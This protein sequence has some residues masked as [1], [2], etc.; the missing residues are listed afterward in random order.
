[1]FETRIRV[2]RKRIAPIPVAVVLLGATLF[3][4]RELI[5]AA[6]GDF[7]VVQDK[8][9]A[10]DI[11]HVIA[12]HDDRTDHAILLYKQGYGRQI[13]FTG[14]WCPDIREYHGKHGRERALQLGIPLE[15]IATDDSSVTSTYSEVVRLKEFIAKSQ[16]PIHSVIVVSDPFHMRRARWTYRLLLD[17][18]VRIQMA[19][20]PFDSTPYQ[21]RWWTDES[22]RSYVENEY[23][24]T[25]YYYARYKFAAGPI[26]GWLARFDR[27]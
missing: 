7:L 15:A 24:K 27:D 9:Q 20:V 12:G 21:R 22:S 4:T 19:P 23:L 16:I 8:L 11:I 1:M 3:L 10:A 6:V 26:N 13:F 2:R 5:L 14:G 18:K 25:V 17:G